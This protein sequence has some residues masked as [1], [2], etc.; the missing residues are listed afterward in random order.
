MLG[1][2]RR[3][4]QARPKPLKRFQRYLGIEEEWST[5]KVLIKPHRFKL[6]ALA[7]I[8]AYPIYKYFV[9]SYYDSLRT[10][11]KEQLQ[12]TK[13]I[14]KILEDFVKLLVENDIRDPKIK[15][16]GAIYGENIVKRQEAL[17]SI[18]ALLLEGVKDTRFLHETKALGKTIAT[19]VI[20]DKVIERGSIDFVL[21]AL[22]DPE[23]KN[24]ITEAGKAVGREESTKKE[25]ATLCRSCV[26][27]PRFQE[28]ARDLMARAS[29]DVMADKVTAE[30]MKLFAF[31]ILE[32][33]VENFK[34]STKAFV[35]TIAEK[36]NKGYK[37]ENKDSEFK[38][39]LEEEGDGYE[40]INARQRSAG[41]ANKGEEDKNVSF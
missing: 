7:A 36:V 8:P 29:R 2:F 30:K 15:R 39:V 21:R 4:N 19:G 32:D 17:D 12:E 41:D 24:E 22:K 23:V 25:G 40:S 28:V 27:D 13:P 38:R 26:Q 18:L 34:E 33:E 3:V 11:V 16:E 14:P 37:V 10:K 20:K 6:L 31:H 35:N 9:Q 5:F 1:L